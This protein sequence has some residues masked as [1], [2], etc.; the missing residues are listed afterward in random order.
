MLACALAICILQ[1][2]SLVPDRTNFTFVDMNTGET[3]KVEWLTPDLTKN[4]L[5][6]RCWFYDG[7]TTTPCKDQDLR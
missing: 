6:D 7:E 2:P 1:T 5:G 3:L 4:I